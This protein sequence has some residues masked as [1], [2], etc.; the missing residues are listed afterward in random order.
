MQSQSNILIIN[1]ANS[2]VAEILLY[3]YIGEFDLSANAFVRELRALEKDYSKINIRI[4]SAGGS[5]FE[6]IAIYNAIL[7]ST[8][9]INTYIDG[10]AASMASIIAL[11]GKRVY[12]SNNATYMTHLPSTYTSGNSDNIK[13]APAFWKAWKK[14]CYPYTLHVPVKQKMN[15]RRF[16]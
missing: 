13:E 8:A 10:L 14:Q 9:E 11:A 12:I 5:V 1:K 3:G 7:S 6:G 2:D 4:N 16:S 15:A